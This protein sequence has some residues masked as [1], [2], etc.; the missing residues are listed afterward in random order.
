VCRRGGEEKEK[1]TTT[2]R[3]C[4]STYTATTDSSQ[5]RSTTKGIKRYGRERISLRRQSTIVRK[6][7]GPCDIGK[8]SISRYLAIIQI[9]EIE[10]R[11]RREKKFRNKPSD[12]VT[13]SN[14]TARLGIDNIKI[15][16]TVE[17]SSP[18]NGEK[19]GNKTSCLDRGLRDI[20]EKIESKIGLDKTSVLHRIEKKG[21]VRKKLAEARSCKAGR[22][23]AALS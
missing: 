10:P 12:P 20:R 17:V 16:P 7:R 15:R 22:G 9:Q 18:Y 3:K 13:K 4:K 23:N 11:K 1:A 5:F 19:Q 21:W 6:G 2:R 8:I 14:S